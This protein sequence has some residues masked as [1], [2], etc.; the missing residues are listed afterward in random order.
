MRSTLVERPVR[1]PTA[2]AARVRGSASPVPA[3]F[4]ALSSDAVSPLF[5]MVLEATEE[6]VYNSLLRATTVKSVKGTAEA[7]PVERVRE[8]L[9][10][11]GVIKK[12]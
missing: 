6:A 7:I 11:Y 8:I 4:E 12:P 9:A 10:K 2:P 1:A 3:K 5:E